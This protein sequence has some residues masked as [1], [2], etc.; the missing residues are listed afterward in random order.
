MEHPL[1][2]VATDCVTVG[3]YTESEIAVDAVNQVLKFRQS[4]V[5]HT[6]FF[7]NGTKAVR[8][9]DAVNHTAQGSVGGVP[10]PRLNDRA[11]ELHTLL[12]FLKIYLVRMDK[13]MKFNY[14]PHRQITMQR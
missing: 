3:M 13:E 10:S 14:C 6:G 7:D 12:C 11:N 2:H 4:A 8:L 5:G 9:T 1:E